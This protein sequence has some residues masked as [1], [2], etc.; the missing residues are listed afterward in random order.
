MKKSRASVL[1]PISIFV[2]SF[3]A[4]V[5]VSVPTISR[6][7]VLPVRLIGWICPAFPHTWKTA[8][9][10]FCSARAL[11]PS[12]KRCASAFIVII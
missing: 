3:A 12:S 11:S 6:V 9:M 1:A 10:P 5:R 7:T 8:L 4:P 2:A